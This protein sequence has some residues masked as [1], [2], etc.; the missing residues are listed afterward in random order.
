[1]SRP[2]YGV[3]APVGWSGR[4]PG[5]GDIRTDLSEVRNSQPCK[6]RVKGTLEHTPHQI[7]KSPRKEQARKGRVA[8]VNGGRGTRWGRRGG[9]GCVDMEPDKSGVG[10]MPSGMGSH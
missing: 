10:G 2:G 1:M 5:G 3:A 7:A 8:G 6:D 4:L 9:S